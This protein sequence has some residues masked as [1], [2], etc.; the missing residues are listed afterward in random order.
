MLNYQA[1][2]DPELVFRQSS[3]EG[4]GL[5]ELVVLISM[6]SVMISLWITHTTAA[7]LE[8]LVSLEDLVL[9][10]SENQA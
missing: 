1:E 9:L 5:T 7:Y 6:C 2:P 10:S 8:L 4:K 3:Q